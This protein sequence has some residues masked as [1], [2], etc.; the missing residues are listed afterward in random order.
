MR[1]SDSPTVYRL[2][3]MFPI[4]GLA[5]LCYYT[6]VI[7]GDTGIAPQLPWL[8]S[9]NRTTLDKASMVFCWCLSFGLAQSLGV[10]ACVDRK[11]LRYRGLLR[12]TQMEWRDVVQV[13]LPNR[14]WIITVRSRDQCVRVLRF[15]YRPSARE[16]TDDL[17]DILREMAPRAEVIY[18]R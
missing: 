6:V 7:L 10:F 1:M 3:R 14:S 13:R 15:L 2:H 12:T 8:R 11:Q 5:G 9:P 18:V 4:V 17:E 16:L